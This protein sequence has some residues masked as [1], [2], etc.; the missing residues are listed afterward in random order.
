MCFN[1]ELYYGLPF[2]SLLV[3]FW[4]IK[5]IG[6]SFLH[7]KICEIYIQYIFSVLA[8]QKYGY[9]AEKQWFREAGPSDLPPFRAE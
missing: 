5:I 2:N 8:Y 7:P 9:E 3:R 1:R 4:N 6:L